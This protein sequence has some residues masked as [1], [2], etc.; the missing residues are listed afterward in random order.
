MFIQKQRLSFDGNEF[1]LFFTR[2]L[3]VTHFIST[4][5]TT[6][7][8]FKSSY[9]LLYRVCKTLYVFLSWSKII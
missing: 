8:D 6:G 2:S 9:F 4:V 7:W 1:C 5:V 3:E